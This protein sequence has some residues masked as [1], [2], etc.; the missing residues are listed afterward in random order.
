MLYDLHGSESPNWNRL[1]PTLT[2]GSEVPQT[3][4]MFLRFIL[5]GNK[6]KQKK[7]TRNKTMGRNT[8]FAEPS[9]QWTTQQ[10]MEHANRV[11]ISI[12]TG[13]NILRKRNRG[14]ICKS[15]VKWKFSKRCSQLK[16]AERMTWQKMWWRYPKL[17]TWK[18]HL[19]KISKCKMNSND[20]NMQLTADQRYQDRLLLTFIND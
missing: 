9:G 18:K 3:S 12:Q 6:G 1:F 7:R 19:L 2:C 15:E 5:L 14:R 10:C 8:E 16:R 13:K 4:E 11:R 20:Q 17:P